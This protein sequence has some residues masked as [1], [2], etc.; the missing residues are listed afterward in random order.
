MISYSSCRKGEHKF[1]FVTAGGKH[2]P[3]EPEQTNRKGKIF[4]LGFAV[5]N[6]GETKFDNQELKVY[7][8]KDSV[9]S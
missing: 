4:K 3:K 6:D 1:S 9:F 7:K 2:P 5:R 8:Q